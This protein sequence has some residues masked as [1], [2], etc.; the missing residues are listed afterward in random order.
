MVVVPALAM[1]LHHVP[2]VRWPK[3]WAAAAVST[4]ADSGGA[5]ANAAASAAP[6]G[7]DDGADSA[8]AGAPRTTAIGDGADGP[9][10]VAIA[11]THQPAPRV[12]GPENDA[13]RAAHGRLA[14]LGVTGIECQ[15]ALAAGGSVLCSCRVAVD[16]SGQLQRL[17]QATASDAATAL[18]TLAE[19]VTAWRQSSGMP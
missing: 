16:A 15:P 9:G 7:G 1:F 5:A 10:P 13:I 11:A 19:D 8:A 6:L 14:A 17:F 18:E 4:P 2:A 12:S 3:T